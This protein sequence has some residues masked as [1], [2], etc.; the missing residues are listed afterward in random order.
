MK[1]ITTDNV[2]SETGP[3]AG[4]KVLELSHAVMGPTTGLVLADLGA[5]VIKIEPAPKGDETR[6][7]KGFGAGF[8]TCFNRNKKSLGLN[9]KDPEGREILDRMIPLADVLIENF[10]PGTIERLGYGYERVSKLNPRLVFCSL[11]GFM[12]GPYQHRQA[13]DEVTQMMGGLAYMTGPSGR[14]LRAGASVVD[15]MGGIFGVVGIL[16]ALIER[17][18][19]GRGR[20]VTA[21]LFE[22]VAMLVSQHMAIAAITGQAPPPMPERG[23]AWSIYDLFLTSDNHQVFIGVTTDRHWQRFCKVFGFDDLLEDKSLAGNQDRIDQR[24]RLLPYL[25]ERFGRM[26]KNEILELAEKAGI[27]FAP[28][29]KPQDLFDDPHLNASGGLLNVRLPDGRTIKLPALPLRIKGHDFNKSLDPPTLGQ[30]GG[31]WLEAAGLDEGKLTDLVRRGIV[32]YEKD[33]K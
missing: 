33:G 3:L 17:R 14:P 31:N 22:S 23:R 26:K 29:A 13:L 6:R 19:D 15:I 24:D 4:I 8:F 5:D 32:V 10:G 18:S 21:S 20:F 30:G 28:V 7:L 1:E 2:N 12:P 9:L 16:S 25:T 27:P 11:K